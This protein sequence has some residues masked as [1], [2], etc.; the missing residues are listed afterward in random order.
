MVKHEIKIEFDNSEDLKSIIEKTYFEDG[1]MGKIGNKKNPIL[2]TKESDPQSYE[3]LTGLGNTTIKISNQ[4]LIDG[5]IRFLV[6][7]EKENIKIYPIS[8]YCIKE[9][10]KYSFY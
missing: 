1:N 2:I 10:D 6:E 3:N 7:E 9:E 4:E 8:I 5:T